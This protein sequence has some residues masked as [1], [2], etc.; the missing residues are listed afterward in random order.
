MSRYRVI[1]ANVSIATVSGLGGNFCPD[2]GV[3]SC[4]VTLKCFNLK[5]LFNNQLVHLLSYPA[6]KSKNAKTMTVLNEE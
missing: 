5:K 4:V 3:N 6:S 1:L 2:K